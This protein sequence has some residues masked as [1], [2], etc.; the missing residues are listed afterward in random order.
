MQHYLKSYKC[1]SNLK[2]QSNKLGPKSGFSQAV[3]PVL[4]LDPGTVRTGFALL[5]L[6]DQKLS[7]ADIGVLKASASAP[8]EARLL[9]I[10]Q[11]LEELY[12]KHPV[13]QTALE[14]VFL[15]KNPDSSFKLGQAFGL[16]SYQAVLH[17]SEVFSYPARYVKQAVTGSG[18]ADKEM[19]KHFVLNTFDLKKSAFENDATDALAVALCHLRTKC[20]PVPDLKESQGAKKT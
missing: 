17:G 7:L 11:A 8:L 19:V 9:T 12:Q 6:Q 2:K 15:G 16:C 5:V 10:G 20:L 4:G 1:R 14:R 18:R 3:L 13:S